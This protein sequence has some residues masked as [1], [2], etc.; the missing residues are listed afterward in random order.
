MDYQKDIE[1]ALDVLGKGGVILYPTDTVWGLGCD[2]TNKKAV[3]RIYEIKQ[4][5]ESKS[6]IILANSASM[7]NQYVKM[8]VSDIESIIDKYQA[9]PTSIIYPQAINL[10]KNV[11]ASDQSIAIRLV[12]HD[13]CQALLQLF[14]KPIVSTSANISNQPTPKLFHEI[15]EEVRNSVDYVVK[16]QQDLTTIPPPSSIIKLLDNGMVKVIRE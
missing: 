12:N 5:A 7:I 9:K 14:K 16:Y 15:S 8:N 13:F 1:K 10:A 2:A 6:L 4:R 11:I 3:Q